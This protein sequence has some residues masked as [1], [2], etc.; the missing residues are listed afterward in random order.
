MYPN[1]DTKEGLAA[2]LI[3][4][5]TKLIKYAKNIPIKKLIISLHLLMKHNV[6]RFGTTYYRQKDG[7]AIGAPPATD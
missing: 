4:Y 6:F 3:S 1:I 7:T 2:L 5:E